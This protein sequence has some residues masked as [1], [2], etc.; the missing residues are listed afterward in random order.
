MY[1]DMLVII[2]DRIK[3]LVAQKMTLEQVKAARPTLDYDGPLR[4]RH[5]PLDDG[6][7]HRS[8]LPRICSRPAAP[9]GAR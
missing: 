4:G 2:R 3:D 9:A 1:R 7:V 5:R 6:D 8:D